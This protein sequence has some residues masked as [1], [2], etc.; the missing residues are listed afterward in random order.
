MIEVFLLDTSAFGKSRGSS[1]NPDGFRVAS[2]SER[3][4]VF[5]QPEGIQM[6]EGGG[7]KAEISTDPCTNFNFKGRARAH[8]FLNAVMALGAEFVIAS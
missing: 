4:G 1:G 2:C 6:D 5:G 7:R 3:V 8:G